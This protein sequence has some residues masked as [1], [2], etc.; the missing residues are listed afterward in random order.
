MYRQI[1]I[2]FIM[3]INSLVI[4]AQNLSIEKEVEK[5][6]FG[7]CNEEVNFDLLATDPELSIQL[8]KEY[9][10]DTLKC[11]DR[12]VYKT[13]GQLFRRSINKSEIVDY[14]LDYIVDSSN[15]YSGFL[16]NCIYEQ[17]HSFDLTLS[18]VK[19][20]NNHNLVYCNTRKIPLLVSYL[21]IKEI[22]PIL[23]E[24]EEQTELNNYDK[25]IL[26]VS[27]ARLG[28]EKMFAEVLNMPKDSDSEWLRHFK[29]LNFIRSQKSIDE[30]VSYLSNDTEIVLEEIPDAYMIIKCKLSALALYH[31]S[32]SLEDFPFNIKYFDL[33]NDISE[34][35][36]LA[37]QWFDENP[38]YRI[39]SKLGRFKL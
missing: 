29:Y 12:K 5:F 11:V 31:L 18:Q 23:Y 10:S 9:K 26:R 14:L 38:D 25:I 36:K 22:I 20:L 2:I 19:K 13:T 32:M 34:E 6:L 28:E 35:V 33:H 15:V 1:I 8:L 16:V 30:L 24:W 39:N 7:K 17:I 21:E 4:N 3:L 37:K 27:L